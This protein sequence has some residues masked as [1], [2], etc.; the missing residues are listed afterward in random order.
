MSGTYYG[1]WQRVENGLQEAQIWLGLGMVTSQNGWMGVVR[2]LDKAGYKL[3][4]AI[5]RYKVAHI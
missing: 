1:Y 2:S 4:T 3:R 5:R